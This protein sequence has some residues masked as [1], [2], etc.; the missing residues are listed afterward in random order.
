M[1]DTYYEPCGYVDLSKKL[2]FECKTD[3]RAGIST[4][5]PTLKKQPDEDIIHYMYRILWKYKFHKL[6]SE[7]NEYVCIPIGDYQEII[8]GFDEL[9]QEFIRNDYDNN[10]NTNI[11]ILNDISQSKNPCTEVKGII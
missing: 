4:G 3:P 11:E 7:T 5:I 8:Y 6:S 9:L 1:L 10:V 2:A